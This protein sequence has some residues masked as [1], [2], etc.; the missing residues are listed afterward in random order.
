[1][2]S[3]STASRTAGDARRARRRR[4]DRRLGTA[5]RRARR[6]PAARAG[7]S[8]PR[9]EGRGWSAMSAA[10]DGPEGAIAAADRSDTRGSRSRGTPARPPGEDR[11]DGHGASGCR[12]RL[13]NGCEGMR[14]RALAASAAR[15]VLIAVRAVRRQAGQI[16][17][18][19]AADYPRRRRQ[20]RK[21][22][23]TNERGLVVSV[24]ITARSSNLGR[25]ALPEASRAKIWKPTAALTKRRLRSCGL[26]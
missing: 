26:A 21:S 14:P 22:K 12:R 7:C 1:V 17:W 20:E 2:G 13:P 11:R 19:G 25:R 9:A 24:D 18:L 8:P 6:A 3:S 15:L 23:S 10:R 16:V 4:A 5:R